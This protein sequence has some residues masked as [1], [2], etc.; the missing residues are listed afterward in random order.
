MSNQVVIQRKQ[1][2]R[3]GDF[4]VRVVY[5]TLNDR[6]GKHSIKLLVRKG[7]IHNTS[8]DVLID[9]NSSDRADLFFDRIERNPQMIIALVMKKHQVY[10]YNKVNSE[11]LEIKKPICTIFHLNLN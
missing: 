7:F 11:E 2:Y 6:V 9:F 5:Y 8:L 3:L 4:N 10:Y 1:I